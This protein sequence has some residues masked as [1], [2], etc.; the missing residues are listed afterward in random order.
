MDMTKLKDAL[1]DLRNQRMA[2]QAKCAILDSGIVA[3][4]RIIQSLNGD[5]PEVILE[6]LPPPGDTRSVSYV[7]L[8]VAALERHGKP[9]AVKDLVFEVGKL[10]G[11]HVQR[12]SFEGTLFKHI[13]RTANPRVVKLG[14]G[15]YG[16]PGW[17]QETKD[18]WSQLHKQ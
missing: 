9:M 16:L 5:H 3:L 15:I 8:A 12:A 1:K 14:P 11:G 2:L 13:Q 4:E 6:T 10:K 7:H 18:L 17:P